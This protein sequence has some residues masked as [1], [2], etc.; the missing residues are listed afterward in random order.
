MQTFEDALLAAD[1]LLACPQRHDIG[2]AAF[3][4][5]RLADEPSRKAPDVCQPAGE[6]AE[7]RAAEAERRPEGLALP[8]HHVGTELAG[9]A[10]Q[11]G[12]DGIEAH[13]EPRAEPVGYRAGGADVLE[14]S[15]EVGSGDDDGADSGRRRR[16]RPRR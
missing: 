9:R 4:S 10:Q 3:V 14:A 5:T 7:V 1:V 11:S 2:V 6:Q 16:P 12:G 13:D 15:E 8:H